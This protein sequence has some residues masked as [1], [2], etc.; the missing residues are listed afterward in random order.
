MTKESVEVGCKMLMDIY[1]Y[2]DI[3]TMILVLLLARGFFAFNKED[4]IWR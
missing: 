1:Y 4:F 2:H 3:I